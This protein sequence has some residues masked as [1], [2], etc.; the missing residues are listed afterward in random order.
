MAEAVGASLTDIEQIQIHPTVHQ[1]TSIMITEGLRGDGAILVNKEGKRFVNE[2]ETRANVSAAELKQTDGC[3]YILFDQALRE[4]VK[5]VEGYV[6]NGIL[7]EGATIE[8]L[9]KNINVDPAVLKETIDKWNKVIADKNDPEFGRATGLEYDISKGPFYVSLIAPGVHHTM[10]GVTI[11]TNTEVI[12]TSGNV[13]P[14]LYAAGEVTGGIHG[15]N[16][17]GGNAVADIIIFGRQAGQSAAAFV[18]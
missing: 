9:A 8:E 11:N 2:M 6:K 16:R 14:G 17:L 3:A 12:S 1:A 10:G 13:I 7:I 4:R 15:N 5:A 18:G